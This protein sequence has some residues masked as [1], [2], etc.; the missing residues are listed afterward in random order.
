MKWMRQ[1]RAAETNRS[2]P[3]APEQTP[4]LASEISTPW[5]RWFTADGSIG[6]YCG[7]TAVDLKRCWL[8]HEGAQW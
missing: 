7:K 5:G 3:A 4:V 8:R 1:R 2:S 6:G